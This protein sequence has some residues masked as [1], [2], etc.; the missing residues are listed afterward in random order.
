MPC[1]A[2]FS[3]SGALIAPPASMVLPPTKPFFSITTTDDPALLASTAAASPAPP[4]PTTTISASI[5]LGYSRF[6]LYSS[7]KSSATPASSKALPTASIIPFDDAVAPVTASTFVDWPSIILPVIFSRATLPTPLVS[8][9]SRILIS[10]ISPSSPISTETLTSPPYPGAIPSY[11]PPVAGLCPPSSTGF[12]AI[13][14][15][16]ASLPSSFSSSSV[17]TSSDSCLLLLSVSA[18]S[19]LHDVSIVNDNA[20]A[21][22]YDKVFLLFI[23][24]PP[25]LPVF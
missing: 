11:V 14:S 24:L 8:L 15:S 18:G 2:C 3:G 21:I 25:Y 13:S 12:S 9:S 7:L 19:L 1:S 10:R 23:F 4:P 16:G 5:S 22:K 20:R 6:S 17:F